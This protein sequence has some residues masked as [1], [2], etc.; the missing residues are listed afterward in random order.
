MSTPQPQPKI[1]AKASERG[2]TLIEILVVLAII[3]LVMGGVGVYA[4]GQFKQA[5]ID[6]AWN[7]IRQLEMNVETYMMQANKCPKSMDDLKARGVI[8][9]VTKDPWG[10]DWIIKC[11]GE[12]GDAD[13]TSKG[14]DKQQG[15]ED[16]VNSWE[17]KKTAEE[18]EG[19]DKGN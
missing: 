3:G 12:H 7:E 6:N 17:S 1:A 8:K 15:N 13:I 9:K 5:R 2:M 19:D 18:A 14:P 16:D 4:F 10:E 11:P